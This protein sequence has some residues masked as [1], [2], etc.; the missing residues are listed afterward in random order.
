MSAVRIV[1]GIGSRGAF[2]LRSLQRRFRTDNKFGLKKI[3]ARPKAVLKQPQSKRSAPTEAAITFLKLKI[4]IARGI[5]FGGEFFYFSER[6]VGELCFCLPRFGQ[7][8]LYFF[9]RKIQIGHEFA[10]RTARAVVGL[11][12]GHPQQFADELQIAIEEQRAVEEEEIFPAAL[13]VAGEFQVA[14]AKVGVATD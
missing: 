13:G 1:G 12:R 8:G 9:R 5:F 11:E 7:R 14:D 2:G 10:V 6:R 3:A 4:P